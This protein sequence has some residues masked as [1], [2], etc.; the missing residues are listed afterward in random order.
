LIH[1]P[2]FFAVTG[3]PGAGK[4][5][6]MAALRAR[7]ETCVDEPARFVLQREARAGRPRPGNAELGARTLEID[8]AAFRAASGRTFFD[9]SL[10]DSWSCVRSSGPCPPAD[11]A[12]AAFRYNRTAFIAPPW[13]E[14]YVQ[15]AERIQSWDGAVATYD[16]S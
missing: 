13:R 6:L 11:E 9:R 3:G 5:A 4:T 14:I 10:V 16:A 1:K 8:I 7:G 15:D 12:V 2:E